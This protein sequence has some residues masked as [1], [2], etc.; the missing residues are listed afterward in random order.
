[1]YFFDGFVAL[2]DR[3]GMVPDDVLVLSYFVFVLYSYFVAWC[4]SLFFRLLSWL[5]RSL[6][7]SF[8]RRKERKPPARRKKEL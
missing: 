6:V 7:S 1:M 4:F 5:Y 2:A 8:Q 3:L